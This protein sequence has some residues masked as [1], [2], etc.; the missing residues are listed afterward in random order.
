MSERALS[1][2]ETGGER[3]SPLAAPLAQR[4]NSYFSP[5]SPPSPNPSGILLNRS[6]FDGEPVHAVPAPAEAIAVEPPL[7]PATR[8]ESDELQ[9]DRSRKS[10]SPSPHCRSFIIPP[11][12]VPFAHPFPFP[13]DFAP[14]PKLANTER[15][16][17][18]TTSRRNSAATARAKFLES[19]RKSSSSFLIFPLPLTR[20]AL[21]NSRRTG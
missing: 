9:Q 12:D 8:E 17:S 16:N 10:R 13:T 11:Y 4:T 1:P 21:Y 5:L 19:T 15:V 14:L 6:Y 18:T 2:I 7:P 3:V 20:S